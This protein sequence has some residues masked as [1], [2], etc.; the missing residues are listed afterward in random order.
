MPR[1]TN[2]HKEVKE[3]PRVVDSWAWNGKMFAKST[4]GSV[5]QIQYGKNWKSMFDE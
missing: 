2:F 1:N 4:S 5:H 3:D